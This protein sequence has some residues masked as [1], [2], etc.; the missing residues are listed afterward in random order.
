[1]RV[2]SHPFVLLCAAMVP[3]LLWP[4]APIMDAPNH[5]ARIWLE[6]QSQLTGRAGAGLYCGLEQHLFQ[7]YG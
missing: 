4:F 1:M 7:L 5:L 2:I 3:V 6:A